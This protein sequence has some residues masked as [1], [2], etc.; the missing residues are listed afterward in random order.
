[1]AK[2]AWIVVGL[3]LVGGAAAVALFASGPSVP[4]GAAP[5]PSPPGGSG[6]PAPTGPTGPVAPGDRP[7]ER[8][9][10][11]TAGIAERAAGVADA[12]GKAAAVMTAQDN[13]RM[14]AL[15]EKIA[16]DTLA[17]NSPNG[18]KIQDAIIQI[19]NVVPVVGPLFV[20]LVNTLKQIFPERG[21]K[22]GPNVDPL[23]E[24]WGRLP[25]DITSLAIQGAKRLPPAP[26]EDKLVT[27]AGPAPL[28]YKLQFR[29]LEEAKR[30]GYWPAGK[31]QLDDGTI[32]PSVLGEQ[33]K[34]QIVAGISAL[35]SDGALL[36][37]TDPPVYLL[38]GGKRRW[39]PNYPTFLKMGYV[40]D[41]IATVPD[42]LL[43]SIP[44]GQ[45][46]PVLA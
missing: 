8:F 42:N 36:K 9:G 25:K 37:G 4:P 46:L 20:L 45:T 32:V 18:K 35:L 44:L 2:V 21:A 26:Y 22:I 23:G 39:I 29:L 43:Q 3:G 17:A 1:M 7:P 19:A 41:Q 28:E 6:V 34:A 11:E 38:E 31:G 33:V 30:R 13:A 14:E 24:A 12:A 40:V 27:G 16:S 10:K 5:P 15:K